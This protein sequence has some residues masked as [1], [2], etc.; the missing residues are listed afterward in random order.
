MREIFD[1]H[2]PKKELHMNTTVVQNA[3]DFETAINSYLAQGYVI[4]NKSANSAMLTKKKEFSIPIGIITFLLCIIGL[5]IYA[6]WYS[7]Q[8]D[9]LVTITIKP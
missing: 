6:V 1:K 7:M 2:T 9:R 5:V 4:S 8:K 3:V